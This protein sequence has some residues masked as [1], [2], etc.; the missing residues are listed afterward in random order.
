MEKP[1]LHEG[2]DRDKS[3]SS[4]QTGE[5]TLGKWQDRLLP[6]MMRMVIFLACFFFVASLIQLA[7][8]HWRIENA[9]K[10][11]SLTPLSLQNRDATP[12]F[13]EDLIISNT[14]VLAKLEGYVLQ[15]RYHMANVTLMSRVWTRYLGF[16]TGM[17]LAL[18]GAVFILGKVQGKA[19]E[20]EG[21]AMGTEFSF[22]STSPGLMLAFLGTVLMIATMSIHHDIAIT[23]QP[24]Y[25]GLRNEANKNVEIEAPPQKPTQSETKT[26]EALPGYIAPK[27][28]KDI[29]VDEGDADDSG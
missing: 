8:L 12:S 5:L 3:T 26:M 19:S 22:K 20:A 14:E 13:E 21:K 1:S 17:I 6:W 16:V 18:L 25:I 10:L 7:Y 28:L 23:D 2:V 11:D 15:R 27:N 29:I 24:V 4:L 9:P